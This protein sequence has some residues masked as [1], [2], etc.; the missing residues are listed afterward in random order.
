MALATVGLIL[1]ILTIY[2]VW[3]V[4]DRFWQA[5]VVVALAIV[6]FPLVAS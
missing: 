5:L 6:L 1:A 2:V 3:R 4:V